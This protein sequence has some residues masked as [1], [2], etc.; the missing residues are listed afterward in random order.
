MKYAL[1]LRKIL[2]NNIIYYQAIDKVIGEE[3]F[4]N[5]IKVIEGDKYLEKELS[6]IEEKDNR[7]VYL[8]IDEETYNNYKIEY[9]S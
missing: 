2:Y 1:V 5:R 8:E 4:D 7:F 6:S 9:S 3:T